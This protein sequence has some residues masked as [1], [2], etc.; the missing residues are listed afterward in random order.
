MAT[1]RRAR[2]GSGRSAA[3]TSR[4]AGLGARGVRIGVGLLVSGVCALLLASIVPAA[5]GWRSTVVLSGS[6]EPRIA[7]GDVVASSPVVLGELVPG[8]VVLVRDP[9]RVGHLLMHRFVRLDAEGRLVTQGD[10]NLVP[11]PTP[12]PTANVLGLPRVRIPWVGLPAL[13]L[14]TG[15][16]GRTLSAGLALLGALLLLR[17]GV[18]SAPARLRPADPVT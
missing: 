6:M 11:D 16:Q 5:F 3:M 15:Q 1:G 7:P 9:A 8:E 13:W 10:A 4:L 14:T 2:R 12:V 18:G 17:S